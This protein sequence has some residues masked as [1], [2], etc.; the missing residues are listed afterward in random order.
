M[1]TPLGLATDGVNLY[2]SQTAASSKIR[3]IVLS[4]LVN[5]VFAGPAAG[6]DL[7]GDTDG[8]GTAASF[9]NPYGMVLTSNGLYV[10]G[11]SGNKIR[12][13]Q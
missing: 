8:T 1:T 7:T 3:K 5:S 2:V 10:G 12:L 4:T 11:V 13:I 6:T 9:N